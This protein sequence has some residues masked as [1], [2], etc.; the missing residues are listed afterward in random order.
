MS[1]GSRHVPVID[2]GPFE[3]VTDIHLSFVCVVRR[4]LRTAGIHALTEIAVGS[5]QWN[6]D[7]GEVLFL[8]VD[9][10]YR[11]QGVATRLL[12]VATEV[13][14]DEGWVAPNHAEERTEEGDAFAQSIGAQPAKRIVPWTSP[15]LPNAAEK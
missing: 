7:D 11:R 8:H 15:G 5:I 3:E 2:E 9:R 6:L 4:P 10:E 14:N 1:N 13:A 12:A